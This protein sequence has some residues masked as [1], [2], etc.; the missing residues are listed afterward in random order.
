MRW[1]WGAVQESVSDHQYYIKT[2]S[3][4]FPTVHGRYKYLGSLA[5]VI[6]T[7]SNL[8]STHVSIYQKIF[9]DLRSAHAESFHSAQDPMLPSS[10]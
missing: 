10:T 6:Q 3:F 9:T 5:K 1:G 8:H 2:F 7:F 4:G